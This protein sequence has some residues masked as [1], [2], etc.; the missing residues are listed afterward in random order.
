[1]HKTDP[2]DGLGQEAALSG[3]EKLIAVREDAVALREVAVALRE[4]ETRVAQEAALASSSEHIHL[5]QRANAHL[6]IASIDA[7]KEA[8]QVK[9]AKV[10]LEHLAYHDGL[11]D[12]PNRMLCQDR[13]G[14]AI[15]V[16]RRHG[17]QLAVMFMDLD[18]FKHINDTL[19]H[20]VGDQLLKSV[21][22]RLVACIRHSDTVSRHGGDEFV[23]LL[24]GIEHA[25]D[26]AQFAQKI[27][28]RLAQPHHIEGHDL[29]VS[30]SIGI[31]IY[32]ADGR[33]VDTLLKSADTALYH[34][35]EQGR[36]NYKFFEPKMNARAVERQVIEVSLRRALE[37]QEFVL[38]YQPKITLHDGAMVGVEALIRWQHPQRGLLQP[39]EFVAIAEDCG[40][41][42]PIERWAL[43]AACMQSQVW[44]QSGLPPIT[45]AVNMSALELRA[46]DF[47]ANL[48]SIL[49]ETGLPPRY[50]ELEIAESV[51][52]RDV[53]AAASVL[54]GIAKLGVKLTIDDFGS[55]YFS[56]SSLKRFPITR[57]KIDKSFVRQMTCNADDASIVNAVI[58]LGKCLRRR[59]VA[60][61]VQ[62]REQHARL[63]AMQCDEGQGDYFGPPVVATAIATLLE[64][65]ISHA[66]PLWRAGPRPERMGS[67]G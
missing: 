45:V 53:E 36:N 37:C 22:Q 64:A 55:G 8:E 18:R 52:V 61:G 13:L 9:S 27:L 33:D 40:L 23:L 48:R 5:L 32:P 49:E 65:G 21:A 51:L 4:S 16:A 41:I 67:R 25:E 59:I 43:R 6:V 17:R 39:G 14:Q 42:R 62:T 29:C 47:L 30:V 56:L 50:L 46:G 66:Q 57:L 26:A 63:L 20:G 38:H 60:E 44:L 1:M 54:H 10:R 2:I 24:A 7:S 31:A 11:T 12:L 28:T 19:G 35:K 3:R 15:E 34:A 58:R